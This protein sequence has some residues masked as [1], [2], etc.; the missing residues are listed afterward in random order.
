[1]KNNRIISEYEQVRL[2]KIEKIKA[3][4]FDPFGGYYPGTESTVAVAAKYDP[5]NEEQMVCTAGR[6]LLH[7]AMGSLMFSTIR[8]SN[9]SI[10][11]GMSKKMLGEKQWEL[12]KLLDLGDIVGVKG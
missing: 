11:I 1:M 4:G 12:A 10:Q 5:N 7:R 8:D 2:E 3:L 6:M 9:G